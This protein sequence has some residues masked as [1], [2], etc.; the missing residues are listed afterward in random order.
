MID[1]EYCRHVSYARPGKYVRLSVADTGT[2]LE[3]GVMDHIFDPFF[4][5]KEVGK[6]TGLGLSVI[7]GI[8]QQHKGWIEVKSELDIGTD[9]EIYLPAFFEKKEEDGLEWHIPSQGLHGKGER[10]LLIEDE[11]HVRKIAKTCLEQNNYQVEEVA[12]ATEALELFEERHT[13]FNLIFSDVVLPDKNGIE[14]VQELLARNPE[15]NV[16]LSSGYTDHKSQWPI[17]KEKGFPF[18]QKPYKLDS[19]LLAVKKALE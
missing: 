8:V 9:F 16:L 17:I 4:T 7:Y 14:L 3:K 10:I 5:T 18:I 13:D 11:Y 2:G 6:G 12:T 15:M 19:L 1:E